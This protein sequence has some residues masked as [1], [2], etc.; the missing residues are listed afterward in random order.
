LEDLSISFCSNLRDYIPIARLEN[1]RRADLFNTRDIDLSVFTDLQQ[2]AE[3]R[4]SYVGAVDLA[5]LA[6]KSLT[7]IVGR[8]TKISGHEG[9]DFRPTIRR[10]G[11][12]T[13][14]TLLSRR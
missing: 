12:T 3:L 13:I 7:I 2:L 14:R 8:D 4:I 10:V 5:P 11:G 9:P 1:L 6:Q